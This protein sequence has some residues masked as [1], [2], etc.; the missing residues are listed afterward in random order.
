MD[1]DVA[2]VTVISDLHINSTVALCPPAVALDDG[3]SYKPS[4]IQRQLW[5][6]WLDS[7]EQ[8][9]ATVKREKA[10][11]YV[12]VN[13]DVMEGY[14]HRW[15]Q[16]ISTNP[17]DQKRMAVSVLDPVAQMAD[18]LFFVRGTEAHAGRGAHWEETLAED[19]GAEPDEAT[20]T[21]SWWH[22]RLKAGGV[23]F[24]IAHQRR[25]STL[26]WTHGG[27]ANRLAAKI[28]YDYGKWAR[29]RPD[30]VVRS[31]GHKIDNSS[32][33]HPV[34]V[35]FTPAWQAATEYINRI[36][37]DSLADIGSLLFVCRAGTV[38][39]RWIGENQY[40][41]TEPRP[42]QKRAN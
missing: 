39:W 5:R 28:V 22:L 26:P 19:F 34:L 9:E 13:G 20:G 11:L 38:D 10:A 12:V 3:G 1:D 8:V 42:W 36:D 33:T 14:H 15:T 16:L 31:H 29:R 40:V 27:P 24:S 32:K 18:H 2:I 25:I 35:V 41:W 7:W 6:W 17:A 37:P 4:R 30:V 21:A 23:L